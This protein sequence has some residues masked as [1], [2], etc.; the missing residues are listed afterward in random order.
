MNEDGSQIVDIAHV[1]RPRAIVVH[2]CK[3]YLFYTDWGRFGESGK[4]FRATMAGTLR[5]AIV[6]TNL[7]QPS[8]LAIDYEEDMLYF[9][10][11]VREV[12]ERVSIHGNRRQELVTATIYPFSIT[13]DRE[14]IYWTDLQVRLFYPW[15]FQNFRLRNLNCFL[16]LRGVYRADKYT[17]SNM[18]EI[19][20]RLDNSPRGIQVS[21]FYIL[22]STF[23][24]TSLFLYLRFMPLNVKTALSTFARSITVVVLIPVTLARTAQPCANAPTG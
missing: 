13:V 2:P 18:K 20:K 6:S 15:T 5:E 21:Y 23:R 4:I 9:T 16:Q 24:L 1:D 3:G 7:T 19:V 11:A 17:G 12:I 10:D 8:G 14:F 22:S